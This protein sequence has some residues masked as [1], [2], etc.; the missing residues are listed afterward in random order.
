MAVLGETGLTELIT[1][2]KNKLAGYLSTSG[3]TVSGNLTVTGTITGDLDGNAT[4]ATKA[5][6]DGQGT[7]ISTN[8]AKK[9]NAIAGLSVTDATITYTMGDSTTG[10]ITVNNV[11]N[12]TSATND[13]NGDDI[14]STYLPLSGGTMTGSI[15]LASSGN[16][17]SLDVDNSG[18]FLRGGMDGTSAYLNL[19]GKNNASYAGHFSL[20]AYD[21][22]NRKTLAGLPDGTLTWANANVLTDATVGTV[23]SNTSSTVS[24][25]SS[26]KSVVSISLS[27][28]TW[29]VTGTISYASIVAGRQFAGLNTS[30]SITANTEGTVVHYSNTAKSQTIALNVTRIFTFSSTTTVYLNGVCETTVNTGTNTIRAV[31]IV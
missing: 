15:K 22:T 12:A 28:G 6:K 20:T 7:T 16:V 26:S 27:A 11:A 4:S 23:V 17:I 31:R 10:T 8:Y 25:G 21:G 29:V 19:Y 9:A 18:I 30:S 5:S 14:A 3:G 24:V 13:G 1:L 2:I